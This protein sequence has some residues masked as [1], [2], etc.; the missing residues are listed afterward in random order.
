V[1]HLQSGRQRRESGVPSLSARTGAVRRVA[2]KDLYY[3]TEEDTLTY[4]REGYTVYELW[5]NDLLDVEKYNTPIMQRI[6]TRRP[7]A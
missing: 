6:V 2:A 4:I 7:G 3:K 5:E 1:S